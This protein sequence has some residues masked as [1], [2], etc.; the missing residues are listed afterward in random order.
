L[1]SEKNY[2]LCIGKSENWEFSFNEKLWG[3]TSRNKKLWEK[4]EK[5]DELAFYVTRPIKLVI[6]FGIVNGKYTDSKFIW[7]VEKRQKE[8]LW[9]HKISFDIISS[10]NNWVKGIKL[11]KTLNL[12]TSTKKIDKELF[13]E[14]KES[15]EKNW[16]YLLT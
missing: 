12:Q 11:P 8:S 9:P 16:K 14:L 4:I 7:P 1:E 10:C 2:Y 6:G 15:A 3:I 5:N 13:I